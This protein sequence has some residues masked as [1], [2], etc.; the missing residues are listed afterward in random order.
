MLKS[1]SRPAARRRPASA[2]LAL[3]A[4]ETRDLMSVSAS[5]VKGQL[6]VKDQ[7]QFNNIALDHAAGT[8]LVN[9]GVVDPKTNIGRVDNGAASCGGRGHRSRSMMEAT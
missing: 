2:R 7:G 9:T 1:K 8:T 5:I 3:E 4:L 6:V